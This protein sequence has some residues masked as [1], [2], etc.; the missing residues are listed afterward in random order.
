MS[1][2]INP[3][4]HEEIQ[5][6]HSD[7]ASQYALAERFGLCRETIRR[8]IKRPVEWHSLNKETAAKCRS[9]GVSLRVASYIIATYETVSIA[10]QAAH[11]NSTIN[12]VRQIQSR[13]NKAGVI[14]GRLSKAAR[15]R[16][17][18]RDAMLVER[19]R[20]L[21]ADG[22]TRDTIAK[23]LKQPVGRVM[24]II[25]SIGGAQPL[26]T[27]TYTLDEVAAMF[28]VTWANA[29]NWV[30]QGWLKAT[31]SKGVGRLFAVRRFDLIAFIAVR[32]AW[33]SY[34]PQLI[35]DEELKERA[36]AAQKA[37]G[38]KWYS[39]REIS[40]RAGVHL[41]TVR[42]WREKGY[43][44]DME[45]TTYGHATYYWLPDGHPLFAVDTVTLA[46]AART[47]HLSRPTLYK[48]IREFGMPV[49]PNN[50]LDL[51]KVKSWLATFTPPKTGR[52]VSQS[53]G[54][55]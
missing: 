38:G 26:R 49:E 31:R 10:D 37:A 14:T 23:Q 46:E 6:L 17:K 21:T 54:A 55:R 34:A 20:R 39:R 2:R 27:G 44:A 29:H 52:P 40:I 41:E 8:L 25:R 28:Q 3:L 47:L 11:L 7:G 24:S 18:G 15:D 22:V 1:T 33:P 13:L 45:A 32:P 9:V 19:I 12:S 36:L 5:R 16:R 48:Y 50:K 51:G 30:K 4:I 53:Q 42:H 35:R 43:L